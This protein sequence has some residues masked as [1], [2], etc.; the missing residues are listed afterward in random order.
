[1][2]DLKRI[3]TNAYVTV[4]GQ[5]AVVNEGAGYAII[6]IQTKQIVARNISSFLDCAKTLEYIVGKDEYQD[7]IQHSTSNENPP[8]IQLT[9]FGVKPDVQ[10][11]I[12]IYAPATVRV[13]KKV[14]WNRS[15]YKCYDVSG[16]FLGRVKGKQGDRYW[17]DRSGNKHY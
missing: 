11:L 6:N 5:Y 10:R 4:Q 13:E 17:E 12:E 1:M 3:D 14:H 2:S 7:L 9:K 15:R 16:N 8:Q